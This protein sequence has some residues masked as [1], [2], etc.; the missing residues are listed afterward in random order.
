MTILFELKK[1]CGWMLTLVRLDTHQTHDQSVRKDGR[2]E[3]QRTDS[4]SGGNPRA[5]AQSF[6][7]EPQKVTQGGQEREV[8]YYFQ[9]GTKKTLARVLD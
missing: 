1:G 4:N 7:M 9:M 2:S 3:I 5:S 8:R 6:L